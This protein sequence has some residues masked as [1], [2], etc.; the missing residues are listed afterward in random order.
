MGVPALLSVP[1]MA[2]GVADE[3]GRAEGVV[4]GPAL[5]FGVTGLALAVGVFAA[6]VALLRRRASSRALARRVAVWSIVHNAAVIFAVSLATHGPYDLPR[7]WSDFSIHAFGWM[8]LLYAA[9]S[10][11]HAFTLLFA[12]AAHQHADSAATRAA[13]RAGALAIAEPHPAV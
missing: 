3:A 1:L 11:G 7:G 10:Y 4:V 6:G 5:G 2:L 13:E 9:V 12:A 8:A